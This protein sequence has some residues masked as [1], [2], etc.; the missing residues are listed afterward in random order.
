MLVLLWFLPAQLLDHLCFCSFI[1]SV[2][3]VTYSQ[4]DLHDLFDLQSV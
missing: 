4:C 2:I 1:A 3:C